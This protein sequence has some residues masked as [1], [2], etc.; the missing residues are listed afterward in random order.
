MVLR[1]TSFRG[2]RAAAELSP[3]AFTSP[4]KQTEYFRRAATDA[5]FRK[6]QIEEKRDAISSGK[7][8]FWMLVAPLIVFSLYLAVTSDR[9]SF[10]SVLLVL[11]ICA[12]LRGE[13]RTTLAALEA[14]EDAK[15]SPASEEIH[16]ASPQ[17]Y[18]DGVHPK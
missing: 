17:H 1:G 3:L 9:E 2:F 4:M 15:P 13:S 11:M 14:L 18:P 8:I 12:S 6:A 5:A 10:T 16:T 7:V